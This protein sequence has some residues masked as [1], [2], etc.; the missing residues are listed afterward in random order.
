[1]HYDVVLGWICET[2]I[3]LTA[4]Q[5]HAVVE[6]T[7]KAQRDRIA[8]W[9]PGDRKAQADRALNTLTAKVVTQRVTPPNRGDDIM[10]I[11]G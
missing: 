3:T 2:P 6:Y 7:R 11:G 4:P 10:L 1:M 9:P 5:L 8:S